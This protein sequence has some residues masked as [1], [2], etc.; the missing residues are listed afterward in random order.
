[1]LFTIGILA[2]LEL[3]VIVHELG[4]AFAMRQCGVRVV[5][6]SLFGFPSLGFISVPV[7]IR[8]PIR[9]R[10]LPDTEWVIHPLLPLG[11]YV[12]PHEQ[13]TA[14]LSRAQDLYISGMGPL[15]NLVFGLALIGLTVGIVPEWFVTQGSAASALLLAGLLISI[16]AAMGALWRYRL[17]FCRRLLL[18]VGIVSLVLLVVIITGMTHAERMHLL[19]GFG[20]L[21]SI[22]DFYIWSQAVASY[23]VKDIMA[24]TLVM[25]GG[26]SIA[27]GAFNL[28]P[29]LP[30]DG[31]HMMS[32][33]VPN[34]LRKPY[35]AISVGLVY[36]LL[37]ISLWNDAVLVARLL[38]A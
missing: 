23:G 22:K 34:V 20:F 10:W 37:V 17:F 8:L 4:H 9:A 12:V 11:A 3:S 33:Y 29:L 19:A 7:T 35:S 1:M 31:G 28:I 14:H 25:S 15:T 30:L 24:Y 27:L 32:H 18:A 2:L 26:L 38:W 21:T 6:I 13:D 36:P 5:R 16:I